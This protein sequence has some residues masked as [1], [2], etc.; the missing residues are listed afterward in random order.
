MK[1][2]ISLFTISKDIISQM[3]LAKIDFKQHLIVSFIEI[4]EILIKI[5]HKLLKLKDT[6]SLLLFQFLEKEE[7]PDLHSTYLPS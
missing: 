2:V 1:K 3:T 4:Q 5:T 7:G 6:N